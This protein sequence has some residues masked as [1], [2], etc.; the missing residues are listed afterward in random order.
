[1]LRPGVL[2]LSAAAAVVLALLTLVV[3]R[4]IR[5]ATIGK[6]QQ[7]QQQ[8]D[9]LERKV[10]GGEAIL[11]LRGYQAVEQPVPA[12][13]AEPEP[14]NNGSPTDIIEKFATR[15]KERR[16]RLGLRNREEGDD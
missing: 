11:A 7:L 10:E 4:T 1:V 5:T 14:V 12:I 8:Y 16:G 3:L 13:E 2:E 6:V 9:E 15:Q